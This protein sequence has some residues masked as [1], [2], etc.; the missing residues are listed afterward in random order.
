V[1]AETS[2]TL[3]RGIQVLFLLAE[4]TDGMRVTDVARELG[5]SRTI[6]YRLMATLERHALVR[7]A[8]D[9]R[10]RLGLRLLTMAKSVQPLLCDAAIP[11][12]RSLA[13]ELA[14]TV[15]LAVVDGGEV[16][17]VTVADPPGGDVHLASRV[18]QR[19]KVEQSAAGQAVM[20]ARAGRRD[21]QEEQ[22]PMTMRVVPGSSARF[23][24]VAL[25]GVP[26]VE[27]AVVAMMLASTDDAEV[28][29]A[30]ARA[31]RDVCASLH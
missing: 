20:A 30:V 31:A 7:R 1:I 16:L 18:G 23:I 5:V 10:Y 8:S 2:Q 4:S 6:V 12:L 13:R 27:A 9:G 11:V 24:A 15:F 3:D 29:A 19:A 28:G 21:T 25:I 22:A 26:G 17:T 14:A